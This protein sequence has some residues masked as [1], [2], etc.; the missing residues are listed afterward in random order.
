MF[1]TGYIFT[2]PILYKTFLALKKAKKE[3]VVVFRSKNQEKLSAFIKEFNLFVQGQHPNFNG[4]AGTPL[5]R[6]DGFKNSKYYVIDSDQLVSLYD[7]QKGVFGV[8]ET[9]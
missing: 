1:N 3:F 5:V 9:V 2:L 7:D 4:K 6:F 8:I